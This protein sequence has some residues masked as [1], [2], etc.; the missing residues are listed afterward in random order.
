MY[1]WIYRSET[2]ILAGS[3]DYKRMHNIEIYFKQVFTIVCNSYFS[4][5]M[6][7]PFIHLMD[8]IEKERQLN[9]KYGVTIGNSIF[10]INSNE[11][12][13]FYIMAEDIDYVHGVV[14]YN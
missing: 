5:D 9:I 1:R 14:K 6:R 3:E 7:R 11:R 4:I 12:Q 8:D 2:L 13:E 10:K